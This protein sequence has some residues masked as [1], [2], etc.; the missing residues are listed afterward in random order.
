MS[1]DMRFSYD[2]EP[3]REPR[4]KPGATIG[5]VVMW[6]GKP[7]PAKA[8]KA[9]AFTDDDG[10]GFIDVGEFEDIEVTDDGRPNG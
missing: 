10:D 9:V 2:P 3:A 8:A 7:G 4:M 5:Y 6:S 1:G